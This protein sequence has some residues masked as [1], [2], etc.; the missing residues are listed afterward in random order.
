[1]AGLDDAMLG[2]LL[3]GQSEFF[4]I[5]TEWEHSYNISTEVWLLREKTARKQVLAVAGGI[6]HFDPSASC[7]GVWINEETYDGQHSD[8][9]GHRLAFWQWSSEDGTMRRQEP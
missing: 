9:K 4:A 8:T 7:P 3:G 6:D 5:T 2:N 1:M